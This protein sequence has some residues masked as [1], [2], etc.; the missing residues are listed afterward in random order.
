MTATEKRIRESTNESQSSFNMIQAEAKL[1]RKIKQKHGKR[2]L[3]WKKKVIMTMS[4][5]VDANNQLIKDGGRSNKEDLIFDRN[6]R[7]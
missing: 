2:V 3:S 5:F 1:N 7:P 4:L 6:I